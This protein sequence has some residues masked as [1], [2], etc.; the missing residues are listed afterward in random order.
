MNSVELLS[1]YIKRRFKG[2]VETFSVA[3]YPRSFTM[4]L[5]HHTYPSIRIER[6]KTTISIWVYEDNAVY[7]KYRRGFNNYKIFEP[8]HL[9]DPDFETKFYVLMVDGCKMKLSKLKTDL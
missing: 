6:S 3:K 2:R 5:Q 7:V 1:T 8:L 9:S 4:A